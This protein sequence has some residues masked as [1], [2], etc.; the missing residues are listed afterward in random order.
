M[1]TPLP[2]ASAPDHRPASAAPGPATE[3]RSS[4][5]SDDAVHAIVEGAPDGIVMVDGE[6]R[7]VLVNPRLEQIFG[8]PRGELLGAG[9]ELLVPVELRQA[10]ADLRAGYDAAPRVREMGSGLELAGR[11]RDGST[12]PVEVSLSPV[13]T[14]TGRHALGMVR[15]VTQR[16][17]SE[18]SVRRLQRLLDTSSEA[19][20]L[21]HAETLELVY[22]NEGAVELTGYDQ[23]ALLAMAVEDLVGGLAPGDVE[24]GLAQLFAPDGGGAVRRQ[25]TVERADGE[26]IE[27]DVLVQCFDWG[28]RAWLAAFARDVTDRLRAEAEHRRAE[29]ALALIDQQER[30]ARD[31]H[32]TVIQSLFGIGLSLQ[33]TSSLAAGTGLAP[34]IDRA[35]DDLDRAI[36]SLRATVF[37]LHEPSPVTGGLRQQVAATAQEVSRSL[38][39]TPTV[40]FDG[41]VD[42]VVPDEVVEQL[43]PCLREALANVARHARATRVEV[44]VG[45][46]EAVTMTV[47]DDGIGL[48]ADARRGE[49][50]NNLEQRAAAL[51][52]HCTAQARLVG[53]TLV[54][55]TVPTNAGRAP[56]AAADLRP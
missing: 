14:A 22:V 48:A 16:K 2:P 18:E 34:R 20:V 1:T 45:V 24:A 17:E 21:A 52:G 5:L 41:P 46:G 30:I 38:G 36:R 55:W 11:R 43:L 39:F 47:A 25:V 7:I 44:E 27:C 12:V 29:Q 19:V 8:Y 15:D 56:R 51:G 49:G 28:G 40:R 37:S 54:H 33:A 6:G 26:Q 3:T 10:H 13:T 50:L 23:R 42:Y 9:I 31:L 35:V 53:G 32:D 4:L